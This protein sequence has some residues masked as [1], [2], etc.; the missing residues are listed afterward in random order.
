MPKP[1]LTIICPIFNE[2]RVIPLFFRRLQPVRE[3]LSA[4]YVVD[5]LFCNNASTDESMAAIDEIRKNDADVFVI[6]L[7]R[8]VGYQR[9]IECGL[10]NAKGDLFVIIDVDCEDPPEMILDFVAKFREGY[11]VVYGERIDRE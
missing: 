8:N 4:E 11:D 7:S 3:K 2:A 6:T 9:S 10:R 1:K 5:L